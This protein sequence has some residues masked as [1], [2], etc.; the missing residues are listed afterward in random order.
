[1]KTKKWISF[2]LSAVTVISMM[3]VPVY[4]HAEESSRTVIIYCVGST[5]ESESGYATNNLIQAMEADYSENLNVIVMTGGAKDWYTPAEYLSGAESIDPAENQIWK[6]EGKRSGEEHGR[7]LLLEGQSTD[8]PMTDPDTL[9]YFLD[10]CYTEYPAECYDLIMW[11]HGGGPAYGFGEDYRGGDLTLGETVGALSESELIQ[12]GNVFE[13]IDYDACL[14]GSME[15]AAA[16]SGYTDHLICSPEETLSGGQDYALLL[17]ALSDP[18]MNGFDIGKAV[19]D[20]YVS[21][22]KDDD[23]LEGFAVMASVDVRQFKKRI[24]PLLTGL[25]EIMLNEATVKGDDGIYHFHDE[26]FSSGA[27]YQYSM[28]DS[29]IS[30]YCLVDFGNLLSALSCRQIENPVMPDEYDNRY[31]DI[32]KAITQA[33]GSGDIIYLS[34]P[35]T[36]MKQIGGRNLR[37]TD[38]SVSSLRDSEDAYAYPTSL[39]VFFPITYIETAYNYIE[40]MRETIESLPES[41]EKSFIKNYASSIA[42]YTIIS[43]FGNAIYQLE[44]SSGEDPSYDDVINKLQNEGVWNEYLTPM[45]RFLSDYV[46]SDANETEEYLTELVAQQV[47]EAVT[48]D[49]A[50]VEKGKLVVPEGSDRAITKVFSGIKI[51]GKPTALEFKMLLSLHGYSYFERES[52]FPDGFAFTFGDT[53]YFGSDSGWEINSPPESVFVLDDSDGNTYVADMQY[54]NDSHDSG[55]IPIIVLKG[56][57]NEENYYLYVSKTDDEW[58]IDGI[59]DTIGGEYLSMNSDIFTHKRNEISFTTVS[60]MTDAEYGLTTLLPISGFC[61]LDRTLKDWGITVREITPDELPEPYTVSEYYSMTD[62]YGNITDVTDIVKAFN[63]T[64]TL[65]HIEAVNAS[66]TKDGNIEYWLD[67]QSGCCYADKEGKT[68]L[69]DTVIPAYGHEWGEWVETTAATETSEGVETRTCKNDPE[70]TETRTIPVLIHMHMLT[71]T[72]AVPAT[73]SS[74]GNIGY[75]KCSGC[76]KIFSDASGENEI[77]IEDTVT[78]ML[79]HSWDNGTVTTPATCTEDGVKTY[80]CLLCG[81][82]KTES[83]PKTGHEWGEWVETTPATKTNFGLET[84]ICRN[85]PEHTETRTLPVLKPYPEEDIPKTSD[86]RY[87][88]YWIFIMSLSMSALVV[89]A[90]HERSSKKKE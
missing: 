18:S 10:Y 39:S 6:L 57:I 84:R 56:L 24:L 35:E 53:T 59:S 30:E 43:V 45:I 88:G 89:F 7:M 87:S 9:A 50:A 71:K 69:D 61:A 17:S 14:M 68:P 12:N 47:D 3:I 16:L 64:V 60:P 49:D 75:W 86:N 48:S 29:V 23:D 31:T 80:A 41:D 13:L 36:L 22:Y 52:Y 42:C 66:C 37:G 33:L 73:C 81:E 4:A 72:D 77:G 26:L 82:T 70:H 65:K 74:S 28:I 2:I 8:K 5:L 20:K 90:A 83:I 51:Y 1:M 11:D 25:S 38:G 44:D 15:I 63:E 85:D 27:A 40:A 21:E 67:E 32:A 76:K 34:K 58:K 19:A 46:F 78:A 79:E 55:Y 62:I 54:T